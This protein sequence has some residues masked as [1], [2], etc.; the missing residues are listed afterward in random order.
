MVAENEIDWVGIEI[1]GSF[2]IRFRHKNIESSRLR[3]D[4]DCRTLPFIYKKLFT[5]NPI[6]QDGLTFPFENPID[7][8]GIIHFRIKE[9][10]KYIIEANDIERIKPLDADRNSYRNLFQWEKIDNKVVLFSVSGFLGATRIQVDDKT[11]LCL[12]VVP[13]KIG[14]DDDFRLMTEELSKMLSQ[15]LMEWNAPT[16]LSFSDSNEEFKTLYEQ[17]ISIKYLLDTE[18]LNSCLQIIKRNPH[19]KLIDEPKWDASSSANFSE[20]FKDPI[21]NGRD[22]DAKSKRPNEIYSSKRRISIDTPPNQFV[23]YTIQNCLQICTSIIN[24]IEV[25]N[26]K[27]NYDIIKSEVLPIKH[28][29]EAIIVSPFF[30]EISI[31]DRIPFDNQTLQKRT[32]YREFLRAWIGIQLAK[33]IDWKDRNAMSADVRNV[34]KLYEFW[35]LFKLENIIES[36]DG[37]RVSTNTVFDPSK[38]GLLSISLKEGNES[39]F[40]FEYLNENEKYT[41]CLYYNRTFKSNEKTNLKANGGSYSRQFRPDYTIVFY[42]GSNEDKAIENGTIAYL[43]FDAK[44]RLDKEFGKIFSDKK[45]EEQELNEE[46]NEIKV[47]QTYKRGDLYK[48]HTYNDAIMKTVG[49]YVLYPGD[50]TIGNNKMKYFTAYHEILPGVGAFAIKPVENE[51]NDDED[52]MENEHLKK[53]IEDCFKIQANKFSQL[54]QIQQDIHNVI[55]EPSFFPAPKN[56]KSDDSTNK[57]LINYFYP[58]NETKPPSELSVIIGFV[59]RD[60]L[61][62]VNKSNK[63]WWHAIKGKNIMK[64]DSNI[65]KAEYI[66]LKQDNKLTGHYGKINSIKLVPQQDPSLPDKEE[67]KNADY[68]YL[69]EVEKFISEPK[70]KNIESSK[71]HLPVAMKWSDIFY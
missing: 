64:T 51:N 33:A 54:Y 58:P 18:K 8:S 1:N 66:L 40:Q 17:F 26:A 15:L 48:M 3:K 31:I 68:Y 30:N 41:I 71:G 29:I 14:Y 45:E 9:G 32:G 4:Q 55:K 63:F 2:S 12:E 38:N 57:S 35:L 21:K 69:I 22:W 65:F 50:N 43:H 56:E 24:F 61:N 49:S 60:S 42:S 11:T 47:K 19:H 27:N 5:E 37:V 7:E 46:E 52:E 6:N 23:K 13:T 10:Y 70:L 34:A 20:F 28:N 67:R 53:F 62:I 39:K 25:D 44:Y 36:I 59:K 16:Y